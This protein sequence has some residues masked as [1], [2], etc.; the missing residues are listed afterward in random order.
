MVGMH[1]TNVSPPKTPKL[2][3]EATEQT[4]EGAKEGEHVST[5][6]QQGEEA[7]E[8]S[9]ASSR[10]FIVKSLTLQDLELSVR[11]GIWATQSHNEEALNK[12]FRVSTI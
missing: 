11:N 1:Q 12:A 10:Y 9:N 4:K 6:Q 7:T 3:S 8:G 2:D 5:A